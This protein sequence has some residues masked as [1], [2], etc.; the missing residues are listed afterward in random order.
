MSESYIKRQFNPNDEQASCAFRT[1]QIVAALDDIDEETG[2]KFWQSLTEKRELSKK[3]KTCQTICLAAET[4]KLNSE[5]ADFVR[6]KL[7]NKPYQIQFKELLEA[8]TQLEKVKK[9]LMSEYS[10]LKESEKKKTPSFL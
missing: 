7:E 2:N 1:L 3:R 8:E 6:V 5:I 4:G 9:S 10:R